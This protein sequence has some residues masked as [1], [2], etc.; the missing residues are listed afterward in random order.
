MK[1]INLLVGGPQDLWPV[2]LKN[3]KVDGKW[4][5]VDRG[6]YWL[7]KK[8]INPIMAIGDF[9]SMD[10]KEFNEVKAHVD[11]LRSC[12]PV[13]D[14]TDTQL[15]VKLAADFKPDVINIYGAT[16]GRLDHFMSNFLIPTEPS[17]RDLVTKIRI[18]DCQNTIRYFLPGCHDLSKESDKKYLAF[19]PLNEMILSIYDA[20]YKLINKYIPRMTSYSSNEFLNG[21]VTFEFDNGVLCVIQSCDK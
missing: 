14:Y 4:I 20:K 7:I 5:G 1:I 11:D 17:F 3:G 9:D 8:H 13:K 15:A 19:V 2:N 18:I 21:R 12:N 6:S 16:G 10:E